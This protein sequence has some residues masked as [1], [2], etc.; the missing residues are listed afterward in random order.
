MAVG[1]IAPERNP[2]RP[3][4]GELP[5]LYNGDRLHSR[6]FLRRFEA[7][8][9]VKKAE[10]IKGV[11]YMGSPVS[12]EHGS[13]DG[14]MQVWLGAYAGSTPGTEL[15][16]NTTLIF[17]SNSTFQPDAILRRRQGGSIVKGSYLRGAPELVVE[18]ATTSVAIDY[19]DK[20]DEYR[21]AGV[22]E[23]IVWNTQ[24]GRIDWHVLEDEEYVVQTPDAT[25]V[26]RSRH[27]PGLNLSLPAA[28]AGDAAT[29]L[30]GLREGLASGPHQE[31]VKQLTQ[32]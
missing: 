30:A 27:F 6:E 21:R 25:G 28:L 23:Y 24:A 1:V 9:Q 15:L 26:L 16:P 7:M 14:I 4:G 32:A 19:H 8:P 20:L 10:L 17:D 31:F 2:E 11:V 13:A 18:I 5:E 12:Y 29:V 22:A 3:R